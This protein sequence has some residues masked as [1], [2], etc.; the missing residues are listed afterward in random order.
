MSNNKEGNFR[1]VAIFMLVSM[2]IAFNWD[3]WSWMKDAI[4][5]VFNP[6]LG[7]LLSWNLNIG[8]LIIVLILSVIMSIIQK[9]TTNQK[10][11]KELKKLQKDL[12]KKANEHKHD[13][14]KS[15]QYQKEMMSLMPKQMKLGMRTIVYTG[16]PFI[17][18]FRWF[19]DYFL[20][21]QE[22]TGAPVRIFGF[23]SWFWFYLIGSMVFSSI[24][25]KKFDI[26]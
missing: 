16:I 12:Q 17:L 25:K 15:M 2:V 18:L 19:T 6:T 23:F 5:S 13:P 1:V 3:K 9:Y 10:E 22:A 21:I 20:T 24:I 14:Q 26:V 11:L 8:M 4:H 7:A